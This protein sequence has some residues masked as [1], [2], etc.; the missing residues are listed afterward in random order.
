MMSCEELTYLTALHITFRYH[1]GM[2]R[3]LI[4]HFGSAS[5]IFRYQANELALSTRI[6]LPRITQLLSDQTLHV[7][8]EEIEWT[9]KQGIRT[10]TIYDSSYP[11][12]LFHCPDA[13]VILYQK[14]PANLSA[15]KTLAVVGTRQ[16]T[17]NGIRIT[18]HII[19]NLAKRGHDC[20][21]ISGLAFGIDITAHQAALEAGLPTI[22][23]FAFGLD[24]VQPAQHFSIAQKIMQSGACVS[25]FPSKT[26][27]TKVN[28]LK[29]N[30]I[31][32]ALADGVLIV[33]SKQ[34]GGALITAEIAQSYDREVM[35][36]PGR[37][38]DPCS[39]GCNALI[40]EQRAALVSSV[41]DIEQQLGWIP[42]I[43]E[44]PA[45]VHQ[46]RDLIDSGLLQ[47]LEQGQLSIDQLHRISHLP[48][49]EL[50]AR[51]MHLTLT[52][53]IRRLQQHQYCLT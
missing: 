52:G 33:E 40:K 42:V 22:A 8:Q 51:L 29:R 44:T 31:I 45:P 1:G 16:A 7:A 3:T 25:D 9:H 23:V 17:P 46:Q 27:I 28:F 36:V 5:N 12:R 34:K 18:E 19:R 15:L 37:W 35:A 47:A 21:I 13:P 30:R 10:Y 43:K 20:T 53:D 50:S 38:N 48:L 11:K 39:T 24:H 26:L 49:P 41:E 14:G 2:A 32:A 4:D 6:P